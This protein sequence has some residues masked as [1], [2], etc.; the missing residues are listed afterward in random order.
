M[1]LVDND[2]Q[3]GFF[4]NSSG[5]LLCNLNVGA[6]TGGTLQMGSWAHAACVWDGDEIRLYVDGVEV[7]S[8]AATGSLNDNGEPMAV[9]NGS[10]TFDEPFEGSIDELRVWSVARTGA[11]ICASAGC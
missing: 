2:G 3:Y 7:E 8:T 11:E 9:G 6:P 1:G 10:P 5:A 4:V